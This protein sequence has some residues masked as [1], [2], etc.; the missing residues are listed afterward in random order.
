[1]KARSVVVGVLVAG[2]MLLAAQVSASANVAW[3]I[4]DPPILVVT[5]GGHNLTV[6][7]Q[8]YLPPYAKHLKNTIYDTAFATRDSTGGTLVTVYVFVPER[9]QVV[10]SANRWR[11]SDTKD[12]ST[13]VTLYLHVP[14]T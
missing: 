9:A 11:V 14:I 7:N 5:P 12:G 1:M 10:S 13:V 6:N 2:A 8:V 3:C 4:S